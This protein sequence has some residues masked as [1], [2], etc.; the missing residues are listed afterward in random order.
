[1]RLITYEYGIFLFL[2]QILRYAALYKNYFIFRSLMKIWI[3]NSERKKKDWLISIKIV[4]HKFIFVL[5][6]MEI[7]YPTAK[8]L[9]PAGDQQNKPCG[10]GT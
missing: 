5:K 7:V 4:F 2:Y 8:M 9:T 1:M 10:D 3:L 6:E